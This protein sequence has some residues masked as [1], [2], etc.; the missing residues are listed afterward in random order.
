MLFTTMD[1]CDPLQAFSHVNLHTGFT[2]IEHVEIIEY[3]SSDH[4]RGRFPTSG[5]NTTIERAPCD[6]L[7]FR[8]LRVVLVDAVPHSAQK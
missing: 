7:V 3:S 1:R 4:Q 2:L 5:H 6:K 8:S